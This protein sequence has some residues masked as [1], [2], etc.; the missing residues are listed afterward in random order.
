VIC[1][2]E[3]L[4]FFLKIEAPSFRQSVRIA[5]HAQASGGGIAR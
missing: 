2:A 1:A 3:E 5:L 4:D